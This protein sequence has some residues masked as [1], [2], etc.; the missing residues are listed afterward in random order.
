MWLGQCR[1]KRVEEGSGTPTKSRPSSPLGCSD[2]VDSSHAR[3]FALYSIVRACRTITHVPKQYLQRHAEQWIGARLRGQFMMSSWLFASSRALSHHSPFVAIPATSTRA[4]EQGGVMRGAVWGCL[5]ERKKKRQ[6]RAVRNARAL[7]AL[8][9]H[10]STV[11]H[12][13]AHCNMASFQSCTATRAQRTCMCWLS[14]T[15]G[16][17]LLQREHCNR[18]G[19]RLCTQPWPHRR[20][21]PQART[22]APSSSVRPLKR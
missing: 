9:Q 7:S 3:M 5:C 13:T 4:R 8:A 15:T 6:E 14:S 19:H 11:G 12:D 16:P 2:G 1:R 17:T 20:T 21:T 22:S 10:A 18:H